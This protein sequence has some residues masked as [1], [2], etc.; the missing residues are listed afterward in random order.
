MNLGLA[1]G[2]ERIDGLALRVVAVPVAADGPCLLEARAVG[3]A[4]QYPRGPAGRAVRVLVRGLGLD[5]PPEGLVRGMV[6]DR[7]DRYDVA[8]VVIA[9]D[10]GRPDEMHERSVPLLPE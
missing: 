7:R 2:V 8:I 6:D 4:G 5:P 10:E 3:D 1:V 9:R